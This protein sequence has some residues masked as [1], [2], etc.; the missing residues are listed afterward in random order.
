MVNTKDDLAG[1]GDQ[2]PSII[3]KLSMTMEPGRI[4]AP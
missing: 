4:K 3:L 1:L 2:E